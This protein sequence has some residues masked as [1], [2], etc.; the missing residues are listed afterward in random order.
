M[1]NAIVEECSSVDTAVI[2]LIPAPSSR[3]KDSDSL[4]W[5]VMVLVIW[6]SCLSVGLLGFVLP[7]ARPKARAADEP[8]MVQKLEIALM[9]QEMQLE[10][11]LP[12]DPATP[13]PAPETV[14]QPPLRMPV[15]VAQPGPA[16]AFAIPVEGP[17][18]IVE[19][20]RASYTRSATTGAI[21]A[22]P[23]PQTLT[24]GQGEG[25][26]LAPEYPRHAI[27]EKQ[28]GGV[29]VRMVVGQDGR[30][31]SAEAFQPSAWP[32]LND[33]A[34]KTVRQHWRFRPGA[35][36]VYEVAIRFELKK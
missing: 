24:F 10:E 34:V 19:A 9:P 36:R 5:P 31:I 17:V 26:Q 30:V 22:K 6:L 29:G 3:P 18:N 28:E 12:P 33:S 20:S 2:E 8:A 14:M 27:R 21:V 4:V 32:L 35:L 1:M 15:A 16:I 7:Y 11:L 13:S 23:V 25:K